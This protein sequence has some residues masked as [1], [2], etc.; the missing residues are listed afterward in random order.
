MHENKH[1]KAKNIDITIITIRVNNND[2]NKE[3]ST[4]MKIEKKMRNKR[5]PDI[6]ENFFKYVIRCRK[7]H[8]RL[9]E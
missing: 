5:Q 3:I 2:N 4:N 8:N 6:T 7:K 9:T 1:R